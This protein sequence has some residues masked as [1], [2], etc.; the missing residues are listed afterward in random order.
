MSDNWTVRQ[1]LRYARNEVDYTGF[2]G[3]SFTVP[4]GWAGDPV[5]RRLFGRFWDSSITKVGLLTTDQGVEGRFV[6]ARVE[7]RVLAGVD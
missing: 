1:N 5:N 2:Y 3:D 4:G 6:T 7:H